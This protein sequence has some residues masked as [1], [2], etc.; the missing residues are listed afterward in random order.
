MGR[1]SWRNSLASQ[2]SAVTSF[3]YSALRYSVQWLRYEHAHYVHF[4]AGPSAE[5]VRSALR[6]F[7][8]SRNFKGIKEPAEAEFIRSKL[9]RI[10]ARR[11][12]EPAKSVTD[13]ADAWRSR[14]M[15]LNVSAASKMLW[16]FD[17]DT[18]VIYDSRAVKGLRQLGVSSGLSGYGDY[19]AAWM[20]RYAHYNQQIDK[21]V[22][23][24]P[25]LLDFMPP[26]AVPVSEY[27][28][29]VREDWFRKRVFDIYLWELGAK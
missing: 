13:L 26:I 11:R 20:N 4:Q 24:L 28:Q 15:R 18:F 1:L 16:L 3:G 6:Y 5:H 7:M 2:K 9:A 22:R 27:R 12:L 25:Q 8:V 14:F 10:A 29:M 23:R 19:V 21:V 17:R